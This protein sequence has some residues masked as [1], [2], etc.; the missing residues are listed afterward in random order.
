MDPIIDTIVRIKNGYMASRQTVEVPYSHFR[1]EILKKLKKHRFIAEYAVE[2]DI[3]KNVIVTLIY[4]QKIPAFTDLKIYSKPGTRHYIK[5]NEIRPV[6]GGYGYSFL[7]TPK[8]VMTHVEAK[9][10]KLGG[11]LLFAIW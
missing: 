3:K 2:G 7:T 9:K 11:E 5:A 6:L 1:E 10:A 8:G 4:K